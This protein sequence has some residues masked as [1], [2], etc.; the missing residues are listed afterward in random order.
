MERYFEYR[1][2]GSAARILLIASA[3]VLISAPISVG[4]VENTAEP[5]EKKAIA[6]C[7]EAL[8]ADYGA[9]ALS[10]ISHTRKSGHRSVYATARLAT[11]ETPRFRCLVRHGTDIRRVQVYADGSL[12]ITNSKSGWISAEPYRV[13]SEPDAE[14]PVEITP[15]QE[16]KESEVP[17]E[18]SP[19]FKTP[20]T[21]TGF[22]TPGTG[23]G[24]QFKPAK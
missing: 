24:S 23:T 7:T 10:D 22:K 2:I 21:G 18:I 3:A 17:E 16:P 1:G 5:T 13:K 12:S 15:E 8:K 19:E 14:V 11:G 20:G 4:Q 6:V 9:I